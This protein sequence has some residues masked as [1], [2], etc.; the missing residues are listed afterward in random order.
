VEQPTTRAWQGNLREPLTLS[1]YVAALAA[2]PLVGRQD[3]L[4]EP[5]GERLAAAALFADISGFTALTERLAR[6]G[7][8]ERAAGI[9]AQIGSRPHEAFA[10]LSAAESLLA[11]G[12]RVEGNAQLERALTFYRKVGAI[13]YIRHGEGLLAASA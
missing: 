6:T 4:R 7:D 10:R 1:S 12:R 11:D 13:A 5:E 9:Y 2:R 3:P 8:F